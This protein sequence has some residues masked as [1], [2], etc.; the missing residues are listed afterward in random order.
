MRYAPCVLYARLC[1]TSAPTCQKYPNIVGP[2]RF[3]VFWTHGLTLCVT[4][5][6][7]AARQ[8]GTAG[9][10]PVTRWTVSEQLCEVRAAPT[11]AA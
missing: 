1:A 6:S 4:A 8:R 7:A 9:G 2:S 10:F 5:G 11:V 3:N